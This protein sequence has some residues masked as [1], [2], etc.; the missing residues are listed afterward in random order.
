MTKG[1]L[2]MSSERILTTAYTAAVCMALSGVSCT[3][4]ALLCPTGPY[5][6][7][8]AGPCSAR[9]RGA[10]HW[11]SRLTSVDQGRRRRIAQVAP[12]T[13]DVHDRVVI[14][15]RARRGDVSAD[16]VKPVRQIQRGRLH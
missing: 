7:S 2:A 16:G 12:R 4:V 9:G 13:Q 3:P 15:V 14:V 1:N 11:P 6:K 10:S 5:Q 8:S